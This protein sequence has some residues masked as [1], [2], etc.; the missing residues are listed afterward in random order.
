MPAGLEVTSG[1]GNPKPREDRH[2]RRSKKTLVVRNGTLIDGSGKPAAR[3]D[4]IVIE[5]NRI[6]SV[7]ALPPDLGARGPPD[8][9]GDRRRRT[10]DH[11]GADRRALPRLLRLPDDQGR[12]QRQGHDPAGILHPQVGAQRAEGA[13]L[14]RHQHLGAGR[15]MVHRRRHPRR[16]QAR[17]DGRAAHVRRGPHGRHLRLHRGRRA[18]VGRNARSFHRQ[19][20]QHCRRDGHRGAAARKAWRQLHQDGGQPLGRIA[21]A[22]EGGDRRRGG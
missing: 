8:R 11:A 16:H 22:G 10:V 19:A 1:S 14:R 13:A 4:A 6:K 15:H 5:G 7:G 9:R 3:N 17:P 21:D 12:G 18:V 20:L 2:E